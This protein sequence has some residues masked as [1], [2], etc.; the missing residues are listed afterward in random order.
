[1]HAHQPVDRARRDHNQVPRRLE[2]CVDHP[3]WPTA[4]LPGSGKTTK[5]HGADAAISSGHTLEGATETLEHGFH[6]GEQ[7]ARLWKMASMMEQ[8]DAT[9]ERLTL[10]GDR[11][12]DAR[13]ITK[14][15]WRVVHA[16]TMRAPCVHHVGHS[17]HTACQQRWQG[18]RQRA[19]QCKAHATSRSARSPY[20]KMAAKPHRA[21]HD[22]V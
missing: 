5:K 18:G 19:S 7:V 1:M 9:D 13:K 8:L 11:G 3:R 15:A 12:E 20:R 22:G 17:Q 14:E 21:T 16:C 10:Q 2:R 4:A 6:H